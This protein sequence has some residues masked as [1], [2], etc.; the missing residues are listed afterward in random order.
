MPGF[1]VASAGRNIL[2]LRAMVEEFAN[3]LWVPAHISPEEASAF[4]RDQ[5]RRTVESELQMLEITVKA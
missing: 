1:A 5:F 4:V 3:R 2:N